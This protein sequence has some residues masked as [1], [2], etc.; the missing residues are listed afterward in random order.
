MIQFIPFFLMV[1]FMI[2]FANKHVIS[3]FQ[4]F[5]NSFYHCAT[6]ICFG[7]NNSVIVS[8]NPYQTLYLFSSFHKL[9]TKSI[10]LFFLQS[11]KIFFFCHHQTDLKW[12][13]FVH[14]N[15]RSIISLHLHKLL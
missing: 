13:L 3:N 15:N 4:P 2:L 5:S 12:I 1:V 6:I 8:E 9:L 10:R 11:R 14:V 7:D